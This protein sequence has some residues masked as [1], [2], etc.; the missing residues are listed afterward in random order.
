MGFFVKK[1][2]GIVQLPP[3]KSKDHTTL[4]DEVIRWA[5]Q[6]GQVSLKSVRWHVSPL[7][8]PLMDT[9]LKSAPTSMAQLVFTDYLY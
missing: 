6:S 8:G 3:E 5:L 7:P 4:A 2:G 9:L 1:A